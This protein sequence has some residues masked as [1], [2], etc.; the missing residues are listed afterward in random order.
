MDHVDPTDQNIDSN[1]SGTVRDN[2]ERT[3]FG[4]Y[5][6]ECSVNPLPVVCLSSQRG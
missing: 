1:P 5:T 3:G 6:L 4:A 2:Q